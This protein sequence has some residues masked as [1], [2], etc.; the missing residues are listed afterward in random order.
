MPIFRYFWRQKCVPCLY[1][2]IYD[3]WEPI[4]IVIFNKS[5][6]LLYAYQGWG[7]VHFIKYK[8]KYKYFHFS[9]YKYK[10]KYKY[11]DFLFIKYKYKYKYIKSSTSTSTN[12]LCGK[13]KYT[14]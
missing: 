12:T 7:Q 9:F 6:K 11:N 10:Y 5:Y 3:I 1:S 14:N 2:G 4:T 8:Y 13:S